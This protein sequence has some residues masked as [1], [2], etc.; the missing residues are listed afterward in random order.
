MELTGKKIKQH[1]RE[2]LVSTD[3]EAALAA[4][5]GLP[6]SKLV[7]PLISFFY[8]KDEL[9]RWRAVTAL[10][11]VVSRIAACD[12]ESARVVM[13]RLMWNLNEESGGIGWGSPEAMG[14][15][16]AQVEKLAD[17]YASILKSYA[18][19]RE[20]FIEYP[21][22]QRGV[23]WGIGRLAQARPG[24]AQGIDSA[25]AAFLASEDAVHRGFAAWTLGNFKSRAAA[26]GLLRLVEDHQK[27]N[28]YA[29]GALTEIS[30]ADLAKAA[31][32]QIDHHPPGQ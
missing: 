11:V 5:D 27:I 7:S 16:M 28:L 1:L 31:L 32:D 22:L 14:E 25:V 4:L 21:P 24:H 13:R 26:P 10:G 23:L 30:V 3:F 6:P 8:D 12:M 19:K 9:L 18:E 29:E 20:N 17:E 2:I 15:I